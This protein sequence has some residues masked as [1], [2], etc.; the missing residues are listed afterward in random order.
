[1]R[2]RH[3]QSIFI[4]QVSILLVF[5][6]LTFTN[7]VLDLPHLLFGD[8]ATTWNQRGGEI[9]IELIIFVAVV[10]LEIFLFKKLLR[11]IKILEGFLP[12]CASCK[13]IRN[14]DQ[15]E[16]IENYITKNSLAQFSHSLC[17][18][19]QQKLYPELFLSQH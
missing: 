19:C 11:R 6:T 7:E 3:I 15:W 16:Q 10:S 8:Q 9:C 12:I 2:N 14:Q 13:K 5:L 18:E 1:M 17:P 4:R